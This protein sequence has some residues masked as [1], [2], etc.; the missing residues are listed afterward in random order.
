MQ[1]PLQ[2]E[3]TERER[4]IRRVQGE[5]ATS[6]IA[7]KL[8]TLMNGRESEACG[9]T[10]KERGKERVSREREGAGEVEGARQLGQCLAEWRCEMRKYA[11]WRMQMQMGMGLGK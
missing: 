8:K 6:D 5:T 7:L 9:G 11:K 3:A 4:Q 2:G 1:R 10:G